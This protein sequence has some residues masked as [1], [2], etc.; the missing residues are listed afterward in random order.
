MKIVNADHIASHPGTN[1]SVAKEEGDSEKGGRD[2]APRLV[3]VLRL[4]LN[5]P[6]L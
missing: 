4:S 5:T 1:V 6:F 3:C 2:M